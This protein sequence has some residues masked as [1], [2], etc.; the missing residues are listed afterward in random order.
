MINCNQ[1]KTPTSAIK[2]QRGHDHV[3]EEIKINGNLQKNKSQI[4]GDYN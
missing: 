1:Y 3:S 4:N 2:L